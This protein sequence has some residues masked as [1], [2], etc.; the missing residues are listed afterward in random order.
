M[1]ERA[2]LVHLQAKRVHGWGIENLHIGCYECHI[3]YMHNNGGREKIVPA[4]GV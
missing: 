2:H 1:F 4:K 3:I